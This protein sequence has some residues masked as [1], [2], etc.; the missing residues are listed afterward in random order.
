MNAR[1]EAAL[2]AAF[3]GLPGCA[4]ALDLATGKPLAHWRPDLVKSWAAAPGSVLKP[5]VLAT[6]DPLDA[7][8]PCAR[9]LLINGVRL[10]CTHTPQTAP[11]N[12]AEA[13]ALSCNSWFAQRAALLDP[14]KLTAAL[15]GAEFSAPATP[16]DLQLL[17]L[18]ARGIR[19]TPAWLARA[20]LRLLH[21]ATEPIRAGLALAVAEGTAHAARPA[22]GGKTGTSREAS[23]FAGFDRRMLLVVAL[24]GGAGGADAAPLAAKIFEK[25]AS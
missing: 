9:R 5:L 17:A 23:W 11:L 7:A 22:L 1:A 13:L 14:R 2:R 4:T 8:L 16:E 15:A 20:Y 24:P 25:C 21:S 19:V 10:D 3:R 18:G 12:A 6:L